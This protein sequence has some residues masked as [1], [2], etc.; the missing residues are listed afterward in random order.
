[1]G[2]SGSV[3]A[4]LVFFRDGVKHL[5]VGRFGVTWPGLIPRAMPRGALRNPGRGVRVPSSGFRGAAYRR[6]NGDG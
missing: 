5:G 4:R 6:G 2:V 3:S 1:M